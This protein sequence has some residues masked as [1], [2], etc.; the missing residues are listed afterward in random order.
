[1][2]YWIGVASKEHVIRGVQG[3]FDQVCH[4]KEG[5]LKQISPQD[6]IIY[7]S[8]TIKFGEKSPCQ[9]FKP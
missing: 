8:P 1:M 9:A 2:R 7:Y 4:M 3:G 5:P 6:W